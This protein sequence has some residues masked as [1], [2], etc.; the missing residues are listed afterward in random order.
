MPKSHPTETIYEKVVKEKKRLPP[1]VLAPQQ[2]R[3]PAPAREAFFTT[4]EPSLNIKLASHGITERKANLR[5]MELRQKAIDSWMH[6]RD[7]EAKAKLRDASNTSRSA[8][9]AGKSIYEKHGYV[10]SK[11]HGSLGAGGASS[12]LSK[13][14]LPLSV[15]T[16]LLRGDSSLRGD[17]STLSNRPR[18]SYS[19]SWRVCPENRFV[20]DPSTF[21]PAPRGG[22]R[23]P[24]EWPDVDPV[25]KREFVVPPALTDGNP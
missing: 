2:F 12:L 24:K 9:D 23:T 22:N 4:A 6:K 13:N 1:Q 25:G 7:E 5:R 10:K 15:S 8:I 16:M 3:H 18:K 20:F 11:S 21:L 17:Q 14:S 19:K